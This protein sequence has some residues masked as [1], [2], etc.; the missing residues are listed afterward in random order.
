MR[1]PLPALA[2]VGLLALGACRQEAAA[3]PVD[4]ASAPAAP[5]HLYACTVRVERSGKPPHAASSGSGASEAEAR[6][7]A[8]SSACQEVGGGADCLAGTAAWTQ[9]LICAEAEGEAV[10][11]VRCAVTVDGP[12]P[13]RAGSATV[14]DATSLDDVC[15]RA[16][17]AACDRVVGGAACR[18][19]KDG[20]R[21][22]SRERSKRFAN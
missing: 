11:R 6:R 18:E 9:A 3:P 1:P 10:G 4:A 12:A 17:V 22:A 8:L 5:R 16:V 14:E 15:A 7:T 2:L 13:V 19:E 20:W 21:V